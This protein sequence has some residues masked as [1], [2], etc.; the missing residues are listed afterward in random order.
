MLKVFLLFAVYEIIGCFVFAA[1]SQIFED[2]GTE[3]IAICLLAWP[4]VL[5]VFI[6]VGVV[7]LVYSAGELFGKWIK[8]VIK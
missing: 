7:A 5:C 8:G 4:I 2:C 1:L 6:L 3:V